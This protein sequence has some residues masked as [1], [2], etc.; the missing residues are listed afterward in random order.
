LKDDGNQLLI[1][2]FPDSTLSAHYLLSTIIDNFIFVIV[3]TLLS[4]GDVVIHRFDIRKDMI[5]SNA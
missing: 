2:A 3:T 4:M 1:A 5:V